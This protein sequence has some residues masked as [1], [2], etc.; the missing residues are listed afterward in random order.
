MNWTLE[1]IVLP[2]TDVDRAKA[3][4]MDKAGFHLDNDVWPDPAVRI[5]QL[6]PLGSGCSI[7][8]GPE[9]EGAL[10]GSVKGLQLV[11]S[12]IDAARAELL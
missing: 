12:D 9:L 6:T 4:Y 1:V 5:V 2:V 11:V 7:C 10:P 8:L 3:F